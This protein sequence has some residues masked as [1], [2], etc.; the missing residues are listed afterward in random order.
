[1]ERSSKALCVRSKVAFLNESSEIRAC[2]SMHFFI[3]TLE[4]LG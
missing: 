3:D 4:S 1:M 2:I